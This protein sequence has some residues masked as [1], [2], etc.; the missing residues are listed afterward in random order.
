MVE[1]PSDAIDSF[2]LVLSSGGI[3]STTAI[4]LSLSEGLN[5]ETLFIEYGQ[6]AAG[7]ESLASATVAEHYGVRRRTLRLEGLSFATGEIQARNAFLLHTALLAFP[8]VAGSILLA[9]HAGTPY[10]DCSSGFVQEMQRSYDFHASGAITIAAPF[11]DMDKGEVFALASEFGVP[12]E[13]THS[14]E[15]NDVA[16]G[17]CLSC[18][19]RE[20]LLA[21]A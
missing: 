19:D 2:A 10:R 6:A 11:I 14:C 16:C 18:L 17:E 12:I 1:K 13:L 8:R 15:G 3:D 4:A 21:H 20:A 7:A 9:V 5:V